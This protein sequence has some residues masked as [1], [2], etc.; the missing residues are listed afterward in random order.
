MMVHVNDMLLVHVN[1]MLLVH[2]DGA[3]DGGVDF[4]FSDVFVLVTSY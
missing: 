3:C 4:L 2:R 1:D